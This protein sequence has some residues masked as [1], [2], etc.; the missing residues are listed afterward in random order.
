MFDKRAYDRN[1]YQTH[2]VAILEQQK[3]YVGLKK[4]DRHYLAVK[5]ESVHRMIAKYPL[6][7]KCR[8]ILH[9]AIA[10]GKI[11]KKPCEVCGE[12]KVEGHHSD[13]SKPFDV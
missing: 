6:K 4:S 9:N 10:L 2:K 8:S 12:I 7:A 13:Y 3:T 5:N 1:Y 11:S